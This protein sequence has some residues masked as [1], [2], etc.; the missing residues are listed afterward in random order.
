[1]IAVHCC[2]VLNGLLHTQTIRLQN[3][4]LIKVRHS[5]D[6]NQDMAEAPRHVLEGLSA[7]RGSAAKTSKGAAV[8]RAAALDPLR[9]GREGGG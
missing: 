4:V 1:M 9:E 3:N 7:R 5:P 8:A 6:I 2:S